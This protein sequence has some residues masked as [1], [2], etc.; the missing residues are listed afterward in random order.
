M[1]AIGIDT[2]KATLA[3]CAID[4]LGRPAA[5]QTFPN[6]PAGHAALLAWAREVSSGA[7][8]GLEG[9][10]GFGAAAARFLLAAGEDVV[11]APPQPSRAAPQPARRQERPG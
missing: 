8:I 11:E 1:Q 9:S 6:D 5:E 3:A 2:H 4:E 10:A 7:R